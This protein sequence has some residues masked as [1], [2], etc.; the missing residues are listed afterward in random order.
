MTGS[1]LEESGIHTSGMYGGGTIR[2][3]TRLGNWETSHGQLIGRDITH[4]Y[5]REIP[6][7]KF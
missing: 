6:P 4:G 7:P 1:E 5:K 2:L 3:D